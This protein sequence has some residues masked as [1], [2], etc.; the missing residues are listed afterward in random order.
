MRSLNRV[1]M[2]IRQDY[3]QLMSAQLHHFDMQ[4]A[5]G[6]QPKTLE[7]GNGVIEINGP[8]VKNQDA[9][10]SYL[11]DAVSYAEIREAI[12]RAENSPEV[13]RI[14]LAIDSPGGQVTGCFELAAYIAK[15]K[16]PIVAHTDG[17]ICSAAYLLAAACNSIY[18][19]S[20]SNQVGSIGVV[21]VHT[22]RSKQNEQHGETV[23]EVVSG[24]YKNAG[25]P[26]KPLNEDSMQHLKN[27]VDG[28]AKLFF[29]SVHNYRPG[30]SVHA[31]AALEAKVLLG[32]EAV[33]SVLVDGVAT[34]DDIQSTG[35]ASG[36]GIPETASRAVKQQKEVIQMSFMKMVDSVQQKENCT[37][38]AA[39]E[40]VLDTPEGESAH[41]E[42]LNDMSGT[43]KPKAEPVKSQFM[44]LVEARKRQT[45][46]SLKKT[47]GDLIVEKPAEY[48]EF[49]NA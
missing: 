45:G 49:L 11:F 9:A 38:R 6:Y 3:L 41:A 18:I 36:V 29:E 10:L 40:M 23:T 34:L 21:A 32:Q 42:F 1:P 33:S 46:E 15:V 22:D 7:T 31:I 14:V 5:S 19:S 12:Q 4:R 48:R 39:M 25:S 20:Y 17:Q 16:K 35:K 2:M 8:L 30:L 26:N 37:R 47:M 13:E 28:L 43:Q 44:L 24:K 27:Q